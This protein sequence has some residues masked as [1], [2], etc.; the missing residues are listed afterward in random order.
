MV[1]TAQPPSP[2]RAALVAAVQAVRDRA[3]ERAHTEAAL[4]LAEEDISASWRQIS[5]LEDKL[6]NRPQTAAEAMLERARGHHITALIQQQILDEETPFSKDLKAQLA[7]ANDILEDRR[8]VRDNLKKRIAEFEYDPTIERAQ[9]AARGVV[10]DEAGAFIAQKIAEVES[11]TMALVRARADLGWFES[12]RVF[13]TF[14][15]DQPEPLRDALHPYH[16]TADRMAR[17][18]RASSAWAT[19][20]DGLLADPAMPLPTLEK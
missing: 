19:V 1:K 9:E 16:E 15:R 18:A 4:A 7:L 14:D 13:G 20:I 10:R 12:H 3:D 6:R 17:A 8:Q 11:A 2:A 5:A